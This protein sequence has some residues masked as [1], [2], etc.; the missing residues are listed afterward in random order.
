[1]KGSNMMGKH[2]RSENRKTYSIAEIGELL[3]VGKNA[4]YNAVHRKEI[5]VIRIG[6]RLLVPKAAFDKLLEKAE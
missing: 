3:G 5:P 2:N 4:A 6:G 1:M